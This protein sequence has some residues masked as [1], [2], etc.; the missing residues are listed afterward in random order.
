MGLSS[1]RATSAAGSAATGGGAL[2]ASLMTFQ[3]DGIV[4]SSRLPE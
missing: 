3:P 2:S 1:A 4:K